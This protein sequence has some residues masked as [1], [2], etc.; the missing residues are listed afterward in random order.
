MFERLNL[1]YLVISFCIG[2]GYIYIVTPPPNIIRKFPSPFNTNTLVYKDNDNN[3]YK[4]K[5]E[6]VAC[7]HTEYDVLDQPVMENFKATKQIKKIV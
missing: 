2:I 7:D 6:Q 5:H 1:F 4:Y 3:C